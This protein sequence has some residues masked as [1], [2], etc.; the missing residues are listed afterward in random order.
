MEP[1]SSLPCSQEPSTGPSPEPDE[2][3]V[4]KIILT[5]FHLHQ[6]LDFSNWMSSSSPCYIPRSPHS[7][8]LYH[9]N[10]QKWVVSV[11][12]QLSF[13]DWKRLKYVIGITDKLICNKFITGSPQNPIEVY[14]MLFTIS[15]PLAAYLV[16]VLRMKSHPSRASSH[17]R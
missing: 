7:D 15:W 6:G 8:W 10:E 14:Q 3:S 4:F 17:I 13:V 2:S 11:K 1:E 12:L 5:P 9:V 16:L